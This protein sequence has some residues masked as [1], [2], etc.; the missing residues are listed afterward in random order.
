MISFNLLY[1]LLYLFYVLSIM[2]HILVI[3][4]VIDYTLINGG[5]SESYEAQKKQS[6]SSIILLIIFAIF[7]SITMFI[8]TFR[9]SLLFFIILI[10]LSFFWLLGTVLQILGTKFERYFLVWLNLFGL[11]THIFLALSYFAIPPLT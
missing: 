11:V 8:P 4:K 7:I 9:T 3:Q 10:I 2:I 1:P 5:R 6:I